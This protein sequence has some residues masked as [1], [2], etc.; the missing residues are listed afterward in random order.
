VAALRAYALIGDRF[1]DPSYLR[2]GLEPAFASRGVELECT[3]D[4]WDLS[5]EAIAGFELLAFHRDGMIWPEG[6]STPFD[7]ADRCETWMTPAQEA[8]VERFVADGGGFLCL[9]NSHWDYP[10][11]GPYRKLVAAERID[12]PEPRPFTI[13]IIEEHPV[14]TGVS[15]FELFDEQHLL[16]VDEGEAIVLATSQGQDGTVSPAV[17][18]REFGEGRVCYLAPGHTLTVLQTPSYRRLLANAIDWCLRIDS[19]QP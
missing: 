17:F 18:V 11:C 13:H 16:R 4:Y 2:V 19:P 10:P 6:Y 1:H 15:D 14:T 3:A 12:H 9:H 8:A 7:P 5:A